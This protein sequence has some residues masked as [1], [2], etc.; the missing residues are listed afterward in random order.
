MR[1]LYAYYTTQI[2]LAVYKH[3]RVKKN[4]LVM[5][6]LLHI[7][8]LFMKS[9][10][11]MRL[12]KISFEYFLD[13]LEQMYLARPTEDLG[14]DSILVL[15]QLAFQQG[16][17]QEGLPGI[18]TQSKVVPIEEFL[19]HRFCALSAYRAQCCLTSVIIRE[20]AFSSWKP[21]VFL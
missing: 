12:K 2:G 10:S 6:A 13:Q 20:L 9:C 21:A 16:V 1:L 11:Q 5:V 3:M 7:S 4:E 17:I 18:P 14:I 15:F 19:D 8:S